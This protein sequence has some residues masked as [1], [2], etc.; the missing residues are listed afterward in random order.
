MGTADKLCC[1]VL[2]VYDQAKWLCRKYNETSFILLEVGFGYTSAIAVEGGKIVDGIGG[3]M[4]AAGYTSLGAMDSELAYLLGKFDKTVLFD[5]GASSLLPP[6]TSHEEFLRKEASGNEYCDAWNYLVESAVRD[7]LMLLSSVKK[8][9]EILLSGRLM[10]NQPFA[11]EVTNRLE[12]F[13]P[14]RKL[15]GFSVPVKEASQG[16]AIVANGLAG[17]S[18][19]PLIDSMQIKDATGTVLDYV[20]LKNVKI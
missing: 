1:A 11:K 7:F 17:G 18:F 3:T 8:P 12:A 19:K 4:G 13:G 16:A 14:V 5:G 10:R 15:K 2:G 6:G 20:N 9:S